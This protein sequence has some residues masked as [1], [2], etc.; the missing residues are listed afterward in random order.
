MMDEVVSKCF[1]SS[2]LSLNVLKECFELFVN[3]RHNKPAELV[4]KYLDARLRSGNKVRAYPPPFSVQ[5]RRL[6]LLLLLNQQY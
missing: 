3:T 2:E 5:I 1:Q 6:C 4:A